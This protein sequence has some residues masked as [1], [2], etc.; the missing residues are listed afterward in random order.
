[1]KTLEIM[2]KKK[3]WIYIT[4]LGGYIKNGWKNYQKNTIY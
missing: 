2:E 4:K 3:S 1:M